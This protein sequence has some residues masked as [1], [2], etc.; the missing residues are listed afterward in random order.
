MTGPGKLRGTFVL[1]VAVVS[2]LCAGW[3]RTYSSLDSARQAAVKRLAD[4]ERVL[5]DTKTNLEQ[6]NAWM[7]SRLAAAEAA[8]EAAAGT[9][10]IPKPAPVTAAP[11]ST[12]PADVAQP[13]VLDD[14]ETRLV[15]R[16]RRMLAMRG[17]LNALEV[18]DAPDGGAPR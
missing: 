9:R 15:R 12:G 3:Y 8:A 2:G 16:R 18:N 10:D 6:C 17:Q 1:G 14:D 4:T 7:D 11:P 13:S 5:A